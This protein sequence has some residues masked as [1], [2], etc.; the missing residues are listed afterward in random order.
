[1]Y[2]GK[3]HFGELKKQNNYAKQHL[4]VMGDLVLIERLFFI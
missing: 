2:E 1:M 3:L 4:Y